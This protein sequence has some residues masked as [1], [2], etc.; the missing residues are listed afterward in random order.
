M[1]LPVLSQLSNVG[2][3][4]CWSLAT[5]ATEHLRGGKYKRSTTLVYFD[6]DSLCCAWTPHTRGLNTL[7]LLAQLQV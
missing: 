3:A 4:M 7:F 5:T 1:E 2:N 6:G